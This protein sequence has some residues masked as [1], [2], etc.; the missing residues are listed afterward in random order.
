MLHLKSLA[1][2]LDVLNFDFL[3]PPGRPA[4][5]VG[6][7]GVRHLSRTRHRSWGRMCLHSYALLHHRAECKR[8][9]MNVGGINTL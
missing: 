5:E 3:D 4:L 1:L 6:G 2:D 7:W 9:A 8:S